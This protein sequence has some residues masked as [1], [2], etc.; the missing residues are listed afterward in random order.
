MSAKPCGGA[1]SAAARRVR[2]VDHNARIIPEAPNKARRKNIFSH[3]DDRFACLVIS[4]CLSLI[5][6]RDTAGFE[7]AFASSESGSLLLNQ[8]PAFGPFGGDGT[9]FALGRPKNRTAGVS[10]SFGKKVEKSR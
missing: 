5:P 4:L 9:I 3:F 6:R 7:L 10:R 1:G 8:K 2:R